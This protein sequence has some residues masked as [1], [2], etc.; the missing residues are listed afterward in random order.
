MANEDIKING[1]F[2]KK[3]DV[4]GSHKPH[5]ELNAASFT[6]RKVVHVPIEIDVEQVKEKIPSFFVSITTDGIEEVGNDDVTSDNGI[7]GPGNG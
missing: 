2:V 3:K 5:A 4:P 6:I 1:H 7:H